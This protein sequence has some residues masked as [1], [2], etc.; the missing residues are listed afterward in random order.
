MVLL[1][2]ERQYVPGGGYSATLLATLERQMT[3]L[4]LDPKTTLR[5]LNETNFHNERAP[6]LPVAAVYFGGPHQSVE[7]TRIVAQLRAEGRFVLP[8]VPTLLG[9]STQVPAALAPING[10]ELVP[11]DLAL[12]HPVARLTE[13]LGL[14][15]SRRLVFISYKRDESR[16]VALQLHHALEARSFEV[17]LDTHSIQRGDEFQPM[18]WD[19]MG[20]TDLLI[21][22]DTPH[23]FTS[24]W[25]EQEVA[26]AHN[27]GLGVLQLIWPP[28]HKRVL[29]TELCEPVYLEAKDFQGTASD[30]GSTLLGTRME[31]VVALAEGTRA[32]SLA[33]RK[34]RVITEFCKQLEWHGVEVVVQ[35]SGLLE[36]QHPSKGATYVLPVV[37]H[38]E[39]TLLQQIED[40]CLKCGTH[41]SQGCIIYDPLGMWP[42]KAAHLEWL[43][44]SLPT[45]SLAVTEVLTW[46]TR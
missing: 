16:G 45:K 14:M 7:A 13:E 43:N 32:R 31:E 21:L 24:K 34:T 39:T 41:P 25:V 11:G 3:M 44:K 12:Q 40:D 17:F 19:R 8:V 18:L 6:F 30:P 23:A 27:L 37:G 26:R 22:L 4:G 35:P 20:D 42:K 15:R 2:P 33:S 46:L 29:G 38:P 10:M 5:T 36:V 9:Y 1:E 28:P